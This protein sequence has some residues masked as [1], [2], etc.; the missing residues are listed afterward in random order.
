MKS[1]ILA[2]G[3]GTRLF[4][5]SRKELPKQFVRLGNRSLFQRTLERHSDFPV[6]VSLKED[7]TSLAKEQAEEVGIGA[8]LIKEPS[9]KN[10]FPAI[11]WSLYVMRIEYGL[12]DDDIVAVVPADQYIEPVE[13]YRED[14]SL[15]RECA[16]GGYVV[17]FGVKPNRP[18][19]GFGY[20]KLGKKLDK[21]FRV[22]EFTEKPSYEKALEYV[23]SGKYLWNS[24]IFVFSFKTFEEE[25]KL[26]QPFAYK[27]LNTKSR[28]E[29]LYVFNKLQSEPIDKAIMEKSKRTVC[30]P[31]RAN[32]SD[33]GTFKG[34][35]EV[36]C[37]DSRCA[38]L[39]GDVLRVD[40]ED[41]L[42][43]SEDKPVIVVGLNHLAV[44][45]AKD[46]LLVVSLEHSQKVKDILKLLEESDE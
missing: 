28:D 44:I 40:A 43:F 22:E 24:G 1:I 26:Y 37:D 9:P 42:V 5:L 36:L 17:L 12:K 33:V 30:I 25:C 46:Y 4:P 29:A 21:A 2:G 38:V 23:K 34:L 18:D 6:Y 10:T 39:S 32:W 11:V 16:K 20:I 14:L 35:Y 19:T 8:N 3:R 15:A 45:N 13:T 31:F 41:V 7:Y 27:L